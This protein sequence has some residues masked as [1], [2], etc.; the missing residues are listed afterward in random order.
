MNFALLA[1]LDI[2]EERVICF[3]TIMTISCGTN[4]GLSGDDFLF[5]WLMQVMTT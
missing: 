4:S 5:S 1:I 2:S 3:L